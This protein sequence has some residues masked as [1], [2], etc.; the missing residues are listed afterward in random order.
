MKAKIYKKG[1]NVFI[2]K[3]NGTIRIPSMYTAYN[4][5]GD[6]IEI[7]DLISDKRHFFNSIENEDGTEINDVDAYLCEFIGA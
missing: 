2:E 6:K 7:I 4:V 3:E 5:Q 1:V